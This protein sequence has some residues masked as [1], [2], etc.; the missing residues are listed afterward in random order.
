MAHRA[1]RQTKFP[2]DLCRSVAYDSFD[3]SPFHLTAVKQFKLGL[4]S[5]AKDNV[6]KINDKLVEIAKE[7]LSGILTSVPVEELNGFMKN[8]KAA[9]NGPK[10]RRP[11]RSF[12]AGLAS[13]V[14][15]K[16]HRYQD[17]DEQVSVKRRTLK[18]GKTAW[19]KSKQTPTISVKKIAS[20][21]KAAPYYSPQPVNCGLPAADLVALRSFV[22]HREFYAINSGQRGSEPTPLFRKSR[23]KR[24]AWG[25]QAQEA[26]GGRPGREPGARP[27][28]AG[29]LR[30]TL[31]DEVH[32][33]AAGAGGPRLE[34]ARR[35]QEAGGRKRPA[36][37]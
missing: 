15:T 20:T 21:N 29:V 12:A 23:A 17:A 30:P 14:L 11:E 7:R 4:E 35:A 28:G 6:W 1:F 26:C 36:A 31:G 37:A 33:S 8:N 19:G 3:R 27:R 32:G 9:R 16:R 10:G 22:G 5:T 24:N 34:A 18:L 2:A 25:A 13:K